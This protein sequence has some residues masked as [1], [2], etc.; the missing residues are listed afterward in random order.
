M[1]ETFTNFVKLV[2]RDKAREFIQG[3]M[4]RFRQ[5]RSA[6]DAGLGSTTANRDMSGYTDL[7]ETLGGLNEA[8]RT[9]LVTTINDL[10]DSQEKKADRN[11]RVMQGA[12]DAEGSIVLPMQQGR[13]EQL[14]MLL[15]AQK[16][17]NTGRMLDRIIRGAA[18]A[19][20]MF[21]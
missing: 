18:L 19:G 20:A 15:D 5:S 9:G 3:E 11:I 8:N 12:A 2:G 13:K 7:I 6:A 10:Q 21:N 16:A 1:D 4:E 14:Q 17:G